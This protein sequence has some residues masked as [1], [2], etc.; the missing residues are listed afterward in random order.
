M[1]R[2]PYGLPGRAPALREQTPALRR[3]PD[4]NSNHLSR[5][6]QLLREATAA[7]HHG[8]DHH[9]LL[10]RLTGR[11]LTREQYAESLAAMYCP[12]VRLERLV[13][14]SGHRLASGLQ[15]STRVH[16]L[17]AD[18]LELGCSVPVVS[19]IPSD[20]PESRAS[21][22]G[23]VYVLEGS[24]RGAAV[25]A[26]RIRSSLGGSAP[27]DF[28]DDAPMPDRH[29]A[30]HARLE[31]ALEA[32]DQLEQACASARAAFADYQAGLDAFDGR[33]APANFGQVK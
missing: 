2:T 25:I 7:A 21:W 11:D 26:R 33:C 3:S 20:G 15:L 4:P 28:F 23:R 24:R 12:H 18:L 14:E 9:P 16:L 19:Q 27:L 29:G 17:E 30:W 32:P 22:W 1:Y 10:Q 5:V 13:H 31:H 6:H 8:L